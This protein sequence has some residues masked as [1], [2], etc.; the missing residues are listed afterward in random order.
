V[1][2]PVDCASVAATATAATA[3]KPTR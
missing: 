2:A 3:I 1:V